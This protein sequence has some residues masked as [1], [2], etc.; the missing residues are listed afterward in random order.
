MT[1]DEKKGYSV[2]LADPSKKHSFKNM[3]RCKNIGSAC[4]TATFRLACHC[5]ARNIAATTGGHGKTEKTTPN[6]ILGGGK[7]K[8]LMKSPR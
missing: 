2:D 5:L 8:I 1:A 3:I 6:G 4:L 7:A